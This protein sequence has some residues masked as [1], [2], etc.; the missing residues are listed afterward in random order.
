MVRLRFVV[1]VMA[2]LSVAELF[3]VFGSVTVAGGV[4]VAVLTAFWD[5]ATGLAASARQKTMVA[6]IERRVVSAMQ[7][8]F[9]ST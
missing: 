7:V 4:I 2:S 6:A 3:A 1:R 8:K 5:H 9:A